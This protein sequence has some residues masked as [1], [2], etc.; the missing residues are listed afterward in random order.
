MPLSPGFAASSITEVLNT[1]LNK[2]ITSPVQTP[3]A[4]TAS[5]SSQLTFSRVKDR[6]GMGEGWG[7]LSSPHPT[8]AGS[9]SV[10]SSQDHHSY[11]APKTRLPG[12]ELG[13]SCNDWDTQPGTLLVDTLTR[14][15]NQLFC[16]PSPLKS[17]AR[18][19]NRWVFW[20]N[21]PTPED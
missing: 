3:A 17:P 12:Q 6:T 5:D 13:R 16:P 1:F 8:V 10:F 7:T 19:S 4:Q 2:L 15:R 20:R 9:V 14:P 18:F 11:S 21:L